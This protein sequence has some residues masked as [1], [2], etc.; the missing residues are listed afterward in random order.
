ML[1]LEELLKPAIDTP[2][3]PPRKQTP[4]AL[5]RVDPSRAGVEEQTRAAGNRRE[6]RERKNS[7]PAPAAAPAPAFEPEVAA[8][9]EREARA[10]HAD[11]TDKGGRPRTERIARVAQAFGDPGY[12]AVAWLRDTL[13]ETRVTSADLER[14]IPRMLVDDVETLTPQGVEKYG[15]YIERIGRDGSP[16]AV[17]VKIADIRDRIE[18]RPDTLSKDE[19]H[20]YRHA[21]KRLRHHAKRR[22][23]K[24]PAAG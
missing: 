17:S 5:Q 8:A 1:K 9:A 7:I 10:A 13:E 21:L 22:G 6:R 12:A 19:S 18:S 20:R 3:K 15:G 23:I 14:G 11:Q 2:L 4:P 16:R 24:E